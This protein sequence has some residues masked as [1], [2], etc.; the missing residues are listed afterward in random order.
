VLFEWLRNRQ[1]EQAHAEIASLKVIT[2]GQWTH[3]FY[4]DWFMFFL[5]DPLPRVHAVYKKI[6]HEAIFSKNA[7]RAH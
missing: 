1:K 3:R 7:P 2:D 4:K 5:Y 6:I